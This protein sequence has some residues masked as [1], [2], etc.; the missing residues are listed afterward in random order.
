MPKK[1]G[2]EAY[3]EMKQIDPKLKVLL[4]SG[5]RQD[6]RV[7]A[8]LK[9]GVQGFVQKPYSLDTLSRSIFAIITMA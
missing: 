7:E 8:V 5:F 1:S 4:A 3:L 6:E 9:L 2:K